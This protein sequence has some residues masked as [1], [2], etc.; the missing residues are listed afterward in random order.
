MTLKDVAGKANLS[1]SFLSQVETGR[2]SASVATLQTLARI[3]GINMADLFSKTEDE[4]YSVLY[5]K[6]QEVHHHPSGV[7]ET[8]LMFHANSALE[9]T[10]IKFPPHSRISH[11]SGHEGE[12]FTYVL[13][14]L[15]KIYLG[16]HDF[17]LEKGDMIYYN[18][19]L[20]H[21]WENP[22][23]GESEILVSNTPSTF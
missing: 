17:I 9:T 20:D 7:E 6:Y 14:G 3:L 19:S 2:T 15:I 12:E 23:D 11:K 5:R 8:F 4:D 16:E 21:S 1:V 18:S 10:V 13:R 22:G